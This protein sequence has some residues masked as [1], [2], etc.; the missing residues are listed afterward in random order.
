MFSYY[1][2]TEIDLEPENKKNI[3]LIGARNGRGKTSFLRIIRILIH[4]LKENADFTKQDGNLTPNEYALGKSN[5]WEG[6]FYKKYG[7]DKASIKGVFEF[8]GKELTI[9]R[10]FEK[11]ANTFNED[12]SVY[13]D[14]KKQNSAQIFLNNILPSN[15]A[16]FFFFDGE[17]LEGLMNT[18][19]INVKESLEVLLN[20]KTY[21]KLISNIK[22][23]QKDYRK[24]TEDT[25]TSEEIQRLDNTKNALA[26][27]IK[28]NNNDVELIGK[29]IKIFKIDIE[30]RLEKLTSLLVDKKADIK[31]LKTE[32]EKIE[33][34]VIALKEYIAKKIKGIDFLVLMAEDISRIYL[35]KLEDDKT[36]YKL[37]E[38]LKLFKR[39]LNSII[40]KTQHNIFNPDI[41]DIPPEFNLNFD[42]TEFYQNRIKEESDKAWD[43]FKKIK[44]TEID[45]QVIYYNENDKEKLN[46]IF[47]EKA[48]M[49]EKFTYLQKI[50]KRLKDIKNELENATENASENDF[51]IKKY[52]QEKEELENKKSI[53]EQRIGELTKDNEL[54]SERKKSLILEISKLEKYLNLSKPILNSI[55]LS[56]TLIDF[57][58]EYKLKLLHKKIEELENE[59]NNHLFELAH[60]KDWIKMVQINDKFEITLLNYLEQ[61]MSVNSLSAGQ[62]QILA[63][64]LIQALGSVSQVKSF[65]C[66]DTPLARI[67]LE[68]REQIITKYYPKASKQVI[69][70]STNSEIDP[71]KIEYRHMKD[72]IAK[73]YTIVS[74]EYKSSFENGY[75]NEI[76]RG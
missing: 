67:D 6:I 29:E 71:S 28:I 60:D 37:D 11:K 31:P 75:F 7:I 19:S 8:E 52:K 69:I 22:A 36:D 68:N 33:K 13:F 59:F 56:E 53:N 24:E 45:K 26:T 23:V 47:E 43:E 9:Q 21:E 4:G 39:T 51:T 20:I 15:F 58:Q 66:I 35:A 55:D 12:I 63:T 42:T 46:S 18:Q 38:Q 76:S 1:G 5:K 48:S 3:I 73:E 74:N 54:K 34:E 44:T 32:K 62:R 50:E 40:H 25:P 14:S 27:D 57:F 17:K 2:E 65:I 61:E 30:E 41:K 49:Y 64:A 10:E 70:L 16:Q 72:F